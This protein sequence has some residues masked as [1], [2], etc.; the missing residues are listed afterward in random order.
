MCVEVC[1]WGSG[2]CPHDRVS[3]ESSAVS[4]GSC[5]CA[6][7]S[8][9]EACVVCV[10]LHTWRRCVW[11]VCGGSVCV[12]CAVGVT[13]V[14][15]RV[16]GV[17]NGSCASMCV[18]GTCTC[19]CG[20]A[21]RCTGLKPLHLC[22]FDMGSSWRLEL[23]QS[24]HQYIFLQGEQ[25]EGGWTTC[26]SNTTQCCMPVWKSCTPVVPLLHW[27]V[28]GA[29][30]QLEL[31]TCVAA[32]TRNTCNLLTLETHVAAHIQNMCSPVTPEPIAAAHTG[33]L[34]SLV[35]PERGAAWS[36]FAAWG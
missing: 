30:G 25:L 26:H 20:C 28:S 24:Q 34:C 6:C 36:H 3:A 13:R 18:W 12:V 7:A 11:C 10:C 1:M 15:G 19:E 27:S 5:V 23:N 21:G 8:P 33:N 22:L 14:H 32:H 9:G 17:R 31:E 29:C 4:S 2:M 16:V 35:T